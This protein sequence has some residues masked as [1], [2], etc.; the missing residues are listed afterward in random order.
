MN[1]NRRIVAL[2]LVALVVFGAVV[3]CGC[4]DPLSE[5]QMMEENEKLIEEADKMEVEPDD[6]E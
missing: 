1:I 4:T 5:Q 2:V 6:K 3:M